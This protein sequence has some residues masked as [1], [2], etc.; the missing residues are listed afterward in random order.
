MKQR[1]LQI[2]TVLR[3]SK[4]DEIVFIHTC[5]F[6]DLI[7][8]SEMK[9]ANLGPICLLLRFDHYDEVAAIDALKKISKVAQHNPVYFCTDSEDLAELFA[10]LMQRELTLVRPPVFFAGEICQDDCELSGS[11]DGKFDGLSV[12][13]LGSARPSKGFHQLPQIIKAINEVSSNAKFLIQS[14][15]H[16]DNSQ[17]VAIQKA[18][19]ILEGQDNVQMYSDTLSNTDYKQIIDACDV[20]LLPYDRHTYRHVTSGV[21]CRGRTGAKRCD[22]T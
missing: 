6:R 14:Y 12:G 7:L 22:H 4:G 1:K 18:L 13:Y 19:Q 16:V 2:E 20:I 15:L 9:L 21:F 5:G 11:S 17:R 10:P 8:L 3:Q